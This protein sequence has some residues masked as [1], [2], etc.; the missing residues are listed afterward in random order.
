MGDLIDSLK[1]LHTSL[2]HA[3]SGYEEGLKNAHGKGLC[4]AT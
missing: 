2:I 4:S 3:R 1:A